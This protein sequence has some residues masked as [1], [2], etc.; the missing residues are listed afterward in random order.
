MPGVA[1][2]FILT[3]HNVLNEKTHASHWLAWVFNQSE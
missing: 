3:K 2:G 1:L